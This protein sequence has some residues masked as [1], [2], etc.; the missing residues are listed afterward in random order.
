VTNPD[1]TAIALLLDRS[2]SMILIKEDAE[3]GV[4]S[5][6]DEQRKVPGKCTLR[7]SSFDYTSEEVYPSTPIAD[8]SYPKLQPRGGTALLDA[9][10]TLIV[11]F[12]EELAA[13][14]EEERP[15]NV[16]FVVVTDGE[17]NSS[18]EWTRQQVFDLVTKQQNDYGW[19]FHFLAANQDAIAVG[20][21]YGVSHN[22]IVDYAPTSKG[23]A[24]SY[25]AASAS[26]TRTRTGRDA[27]YT[28]EE[29]EAAKS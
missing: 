3:G 19:V 22:T 21:A 24:G 26:I 17:E 7:V 2:R 20:R 15:G 23:V 5:F 6:I 4:R 9:W 16:V 11:A 27:S 28:S 10:G 12:G 1:Y 25:G 14:P 18:R 29:R 8:A 13:L